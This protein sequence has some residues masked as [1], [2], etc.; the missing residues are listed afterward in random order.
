MY[1][2]ITIGSATIDI[3]VE[4]DSASVVS[5][6]TKE[7]N[8]QFMSYKY[9]SK[10]EIDDFSFS[11]GGGGVNTAANFSNLGLK[12]SAIIK[13]GSDF[14]AQAIQNAVEKRGID[15]SNIIKDKKD[16]S[17]FSVILLSFEGDRTVLAHRGTNATI[18]NSEIN[19]DAIKNSK[20]LYIAPLNGS[21]NRILDE[22]A[23]FAE[24]SNVNMAIN[25]GTTSIKKSKKHLPKVLAT[26]E[27]IIMNLEE[28]AMYTEI[29]PRPDSKEIKY[30]QNIIH[31]DIIQ[32]LNELKSTHAKIVVI[33]DGKRGVYAF[34]G[35]TYYRAPE[36]P[37]KVVSTLG[38]GDAFASTFV[39][40]LE[41]YD[42]DIKKALEYASVNAA[43]VVEN[44]GALDGFL[45]FKQ[46]KEKLKKNS[47]FKVCEYSAKDVKKCR[48]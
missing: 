3:F 8:V 17:G 41:E 23:D 43:S 36:F 13:V 12:T 26:A 44:F 7:K 5:V 25:L 34:D 10:L 28:A 6:A 47:D 4:S 42:W 18:K 35:K 21:T 9:G 48:I 22:I 19:Y 14:Y 37:A 31:P 1:D 38:A 24:K 27:V 33:T 45:T 46:I 11:V 40:T 29:Q 16:S 2:V 15:T 20:W 32:I 30:S 39:A